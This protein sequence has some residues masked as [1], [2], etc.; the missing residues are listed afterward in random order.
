[1]RD[2]VE[3][4]ARVYLEIRREGCIQFDEM[5]V[6]IDCSAEMTSKVKF[7]LQSIKHQFVGKPSARKTIHDSL[8]RKLATDDD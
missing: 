4:L 5:L 3:R 2:A 8:L 6:K 1:M 7:K